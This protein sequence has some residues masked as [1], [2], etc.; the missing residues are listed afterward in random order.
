MKILLLLICFISTSVF[1]GERKDH[2]AGIK[3]ATDKN[4]NYFSRGLHNNGAFKNDPV[5]SK[6]NQAVED[7][8]RKVGSGV[9][10]NTESPNKGKPGSST[11][12]W[13]DGNAT[14][15]QKPGSKK[16]NHESTIGDGDGKH[17][18][19]TN[20][21]ATS[22]KKPGSKKPTCSLHDSVHC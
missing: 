17:E 20:G 16:P 8:Y 18:V 9:L 12:V 2:G 10:I 6:S 4:S 1:A 22:I 13:T 7:R 3:E 21:S 11:K 14:S 19:W 5:K 15:I